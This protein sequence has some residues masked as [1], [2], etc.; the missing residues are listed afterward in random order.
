MRSIRMLSVRWL[1][2]NLCTTLVWSSRQ[3]RAA[4]GT[5][6]A[7]R[8]LRLM[9]TPGRFCGVRFP[10]Y[11]SFQRFKP[12]SQ[13]ASA[14]MAEVFPEL[15]GPMNTTGF[16]NSTSTSS[17]RLKLRAVS[18]VSME[19]SSRFQFA[20]RACIRFMNLVKNISRWAVRIRFE[21]NKTEF[22]N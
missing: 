12:I 22:S 6:I 11:F 17:K 3:R 15:F 13:R 14:C 10:E 16:P 21:N 4:L 2:S 8:S 7:R 18:L 5:G 20:I 9:V 19:N 1:P